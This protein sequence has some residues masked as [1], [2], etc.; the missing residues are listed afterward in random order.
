M[1]THDDYDALFQFLAEMP[2]H[3]GCTTPFHRTL[4]SLCAETFA[5]SPLRDKD[6]RSLPFGPFGEIILPY[7]K[8]GAVDS[9]DLFGLNELVLFAFYAVNRKRYKNVVDI[10]ANLGL[11]TI[12]LARCGFSIR[13]YEPDPVHF[14]LLRRN[15]ELNKLEK[16]DLVQAAVSDVVG[17]AEFVRVVGNTTGSHLA[18]AKVDPYGELNRFAV[19]ISPVLTAV[20]DADLVKIDAEGHEAVILRA[21]PVER[22][23]S[24]DAV[25]EIGSAE[26]AKAIFELCASARISVFSQKI[27]WRPATSVMDLPISHREGSVFIS[28]RPSM[29]WKRV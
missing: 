17:K 14:E 25:V 22:W 24:L 27:G 21:L 3:H 6:G 10:G 13:A 23:Q 18:G 5:H 9:I 12:L 19:D 8:M 1:L 29:P 26:N 28:T 4:A 15:V 16:V 7:W 20:A 11:H 2:A